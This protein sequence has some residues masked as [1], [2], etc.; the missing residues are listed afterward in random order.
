MSA[1][2]RSIRFIQEHMALLSF[3]CLLA[4]LLAGEFAEGLGGAIPWL[5][6]VLTFNSGLGLRV[7]DLGC[8]R[9]KPWILPF[10][11]VWLH[12]AA[13]LM[14]M[15][16]TNL[17]GFPV[18][19]VM[20]FA[21][22]AML[23]VS[24]STVVWIG[25]YRGNV[26]LAMALLLMDTVLTPFIIPYALDF[27]FGATVHMDPL[28]MLRGLFWMLLFPTLLALF[29]NR[30]T[31]GGLQRVAGKTFSLLA[32]FAIFTILFINGGVISPFFRDF[33]P[34]FFAVVAMAGAYFV[35]WFLAN[36]FLGLAIFKN[37]EDTISFMLCSS[38]RSITAGMV[39]AMAYFAPL[40]TVT[41]VTGMLF[42]PPLASYSGTLASRYFDR[43][44]VPPAKDGVC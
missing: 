39:I 13:P 2:Q 3:S 32:R 28:R 31:G 14:A 20:G 27:L 15:A 29:L 17:L 23:P 5:F 40:T 8:V 10:H 35:L 24:A 1:S 4:G 36:F 37:R 30:L 34:V 41:V 26:T 21:I 44:G 6:A 11:L 42:Q 7:Q 9:A 19:A 43:K 38:I 18:D 12:V 25:F 16:A 33:D 22:L